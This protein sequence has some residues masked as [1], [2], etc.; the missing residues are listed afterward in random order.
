MIKTFYEE[1]ESLKKCF[2]EKKKIL[3]KENEK[4]LCTSIK[5]M[6]KN[7]MLKENINI[8]LS[9]CLIISH[10]TKKFDFTPEQ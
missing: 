2:N 6:L 9:M 3:L 4:D 7:I 10:I 1:I 8:F 5:T